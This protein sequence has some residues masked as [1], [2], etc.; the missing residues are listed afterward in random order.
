MFY[1]MGD[2]LRHGQFSRI[3][4]TE[5]PSILKYN[6]LLGCFTNVDTSLMV[7]DLQLHWIHWISFSSSRGLNDTV[8]DS[9]ILHH[10]GRI[11]PCDNG[12][13]PTS[14]GDCRR[15]SGC[16]QQYR[17]DLQVSFQIK[18]TQPFN[19]WT[20]PLPPTKKSNQI[21]IFAE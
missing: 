10:L 14:T 17:S 8:D 3:G 2:Q 1:N 5:T 7:L 16:H 15:I 9:E 6:S 20:P 21:P 19:R 13:L 11:K 18:Y 12:I 4:S